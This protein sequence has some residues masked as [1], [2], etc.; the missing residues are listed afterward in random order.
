MEKPFQVFCCYAHSDNLYLEEL[1]SHLTP[2][3]RQGL[4]TINA[5]I[6]IN[7]GMEWKREIKRYLEKAQ[8]ILLLI[9]SDFIA[10]DYC[11]NNEMKRAMEQ[12][13]R[14]EVRVIPILLRPSIWQETPFGK[15]QVLPKNARAVTEWRDRDKAWLAIAQGIEQVAMEWPTKLSV[16]SPQQS[17]STINETRLQSITGT[18]RRDWGEAPDVSI[19]FGRT[20]ELILLEQWIN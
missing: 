20:K 10:S 7:P 5:D 13:E 8:I 1:K 2:L 19:F 11:Y 3:E 15:L 18:V 17:Q 4:I 14:G 6:D 9:S 12:H 16:T